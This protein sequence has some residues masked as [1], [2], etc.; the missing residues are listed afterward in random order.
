M[1]WVLWNSPKDGKSWNEDPRRDFVK[2]LP[3]NTHF[4]SRCWE[5]IRDT[6]REAGHKKAIG[7]PHRDPRGGNPTAQF[8]KR[9]S[10]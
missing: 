8:V 7:V 3:L 9:L 6:G 1:L 4:C 10:G 5:T 2:N